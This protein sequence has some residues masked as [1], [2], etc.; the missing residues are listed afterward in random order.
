MAQ[1]K[2]GSRVWNTAHEVAVHILALRMSR[3]GWPLRL[4]VAQEAL[5]ALL[6]AVVVFP[7]G[8]VADEAGVFD[9]GCPGSSAVHDGAIQANREQDKTAVAPF[10][11]E[12]RFDFKLHPGA[13]DRLLRKHQ[14]QFVVEAAGVPLKVVSEMLGHSSVAITADIYAHVLPEQ[15]QEVVKKMGDLFGNF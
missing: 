1:T 15:Q 13:P 2:A 3:C 14:Q 12:C 9:M 8:E 4:Q 6:I 10:F 11:C 5:Q 7:G